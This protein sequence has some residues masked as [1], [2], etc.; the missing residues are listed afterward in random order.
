ME[1]AD[2]VR[3]VLDGFRLPFEGG[4]LIISERRLWAPALA[5]IGFSL[6]AFSVAIALLVGYAGELYG[7]STQWMPVLEAH[8]WWS[9]LWIGPAVT[10]LKL[11]GVLLFLIVAGVALLISFLAAS[12]LASPFLDVLSYRVE[13]IQAGTVVDESDSGMLGIGTDALRSVREELRRVVFF[14]LVVG[15]L[16]LLGI[17]IP[18]AQLVT[19]PLIVGFTIFFLPLDYASYTLDRRQLSFREKRDWLMENKQPGVGFGCAAFLICVVPGLNFVAM[20]LLV[21]GGTLLVLRQ[22]PTLKPS[23]SHL[24]TAR[25]L[26]I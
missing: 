1:N 12:V 8:A 11:I 6:V 25:A 4:R 26:E 20:P 2:S 18:G 7:W 16:M 15:S 23:A 19:G 13:A 24:D 17:V 3:S 14:L 21:V 10:G 22:A 9:W 5:P